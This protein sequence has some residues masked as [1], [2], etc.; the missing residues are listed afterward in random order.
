MPASPANPRTGDVAPGATTSACES[1]CRQ[2]DQRH[3]RTAA[4]RAT[5]VNQQLD[6]HRHDQDV[7][8]TLTFC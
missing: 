3:N 1:A 2:R 8:V 4:V 5:S 6:G 7:A